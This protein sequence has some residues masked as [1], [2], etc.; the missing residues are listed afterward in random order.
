MN[1]VLDNSNG[2]GIQAINNVW[3]FM[4]DL[5]HGNIQIVYWLSTI[6]LDECL[7]AWKLSP[8]LTG[9]GLMLLVSY[10]ELLLTNS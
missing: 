7:A 2:I 10:I 6:Q 8:S 3:I 5:N 9:S 1:A 4:N